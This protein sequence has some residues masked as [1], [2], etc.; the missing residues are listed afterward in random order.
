MRKFIL[1]LVLI[2]SIISMIVSVL[3]V[4]WY[5][6]TTS[7]VSIA[8]VLTLFDLDVKIHHLYKEIYAVRSSLRK[9]REN[10]P[11]NNK[12]RGYEDK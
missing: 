1:T 3:I 2:G 5:L 4:D 11:V 8:V 7:I 10:K 6:F 12:Y 9:N